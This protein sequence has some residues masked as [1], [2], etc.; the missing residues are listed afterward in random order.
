MALD[1]QEPA[2]RQRP[3]FRASEAFEQFYTP[4]PMRTSGGFGADE[5]QLGGMRWMA[6]GVSQRD[7][8]AKRRAEDDRTDDAQDLAER[9]HV[10]APLRQVPALSRAILASTIASM[11]EVDD[12]SDVGQ[13]RIGGL[14][15]RVVE[16]GA[17]MQ[18]QQGRLFPHGGTVGH[19]LR[20][21][22]IE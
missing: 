17:A 16:A 6:R 10:V 5:H 21:F 7:H 19:Q 9:M 13:R 12:L 8:T 15:D 14:V 18:E 20:T 22:D 4:V 2:A 11:I 1:F 3:D